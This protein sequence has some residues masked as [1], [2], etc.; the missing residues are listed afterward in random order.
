MSGSDDVKITNKR[1]GHQTSGKSAR[2]ATQRNPDK[3]RHKTESKDEEPKSADTMKDKVA[4]GRPDFT[5]KSLESSTSEQPKSNSNAPVKDKIKTLADFIVYAYSRNGQ[6]LRSLAS[7]ELKA[8]AKTSKL[9]DDQF[10]GLLEI[11]RRDSFLAVPCKIYFC[12]KK[13]DVP[14]FVRNEALRFIGATL[15]Q[16]PVFASNEI[17]PVLSNRDDAID[18]N[19]AIRVVAGLSQRTLGEL[20]GSDKLRPKDAEKLRTNSINCLA[21]WIWETRAQNM[22]RIFQ[23]LH[24]GYWKKLSPSSADTILCL[25]AVTEI[26][27]ISNVGAACSQFSAEADRNAARAEALQRKLDSQEIKIDELK[28]AI[29]ELKDEARTREEVISAISDK[30]ETEQ[31]DHAESRAHLEDDREYLRSHVARRIKRELEL[32]SEGLLALRKDPPKIWVM[33]DHAERAIESLQAAMK[34]LEEDD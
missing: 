21:V 32:L 8:I 18:P 4:P 27:E 33:D 11:A 26:T 12:V 29:K 24:E 9:D 28:K 16:H 23:W 15:K 10:R 34:E 5:P 20:I 2:A 6:N 19:K 30:L 17:G 31:S 1:T 7:G 13:L 3:V 25:E 14:P 22:G